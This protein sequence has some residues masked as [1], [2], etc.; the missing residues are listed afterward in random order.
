MA[1]WSESAL[2]LHQVLGSELVLQLT[3]NTR[4][5][6][7]GRLVTFL[8]CRMLTTT[9]RLKGARSAACTVAGA[10]VSKLRSF[11]SRTSGTANIFKVRTVQDPQLAV[12][13][14]LVKVTIQQIF[15]AQLIFVG[16]WR[17][18]TTV[19][20]VDLSAVYW[21]GGSGSRVVSMA[22]GIATRWI[23]ECGRSDYSSRVNA[24]DSAGRN[25]DAGHPCEVELEASSGRQVRRE[26]RPETPQPL[27]QGLRLGPGNV[28]V[29]IASLR[30]ELHQKPPAVVVR[31]REGA[32]RREDQGGSAPCRRGAGQES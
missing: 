32:I 6:L 9:L 15:K 16:R 3:R 27:T 2:G 24:A 31:E 5:W 8:N 18:V 22:K 10:Q 12:A 11:G 26:C 25:P 28:E 30:S 21:L 13:R 1:T 4:E 17:R 23:A 29:I 19:G 20:A 14:V 7:V